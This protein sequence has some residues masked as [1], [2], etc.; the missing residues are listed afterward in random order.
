MKIVM[1]YLLSYSMQS[2]SVYGALRGLELCTFDYG[3]KSVKLHKAPWYIQDKPRFTYCGLMLDTSR[4]YLPVEIIKQVIESMSYAKL[5][6]RV[7][8]SIQ[9]YMT[10]HFH[11]KCHP[12]QSCGKAHIQSGSGTLWM[13]LVNLLGINVMAEVDVP[14]HAESW[15]ED[16]NMTG[17]D[18]Y[19]YFVLKA[20]KIAMSLN[21][22][23]VN[24]EETFNTFAE[25]LNPSTIYPLDQVYY[26]DRLED[27]TDALEQ[28]LVLG[29][30]VRMWG[31]TV[32]ASNL[33]QT[34]WPRA[35]VAADEYFRCLLTR[36]G[37][38][39]APVTNF[40]ARRSPTGPD[41]QIAGG[42]GLI[43]DHHGELL[44]ALHSSFQASSSFDAEI[45]AFA[46]GLILASHKS[47]KIDAAVVTLLSS[48]HRGSWVFQGP[49][50]SINESQH[51]EHIR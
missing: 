25:R 21:W 32:D 40:Y 15:L 39:A 37:V 45:Q 43:R 49:S 24:W 8:N 27:I 26:A 1:N 41:I 17:K 51:A 18:A 11:L 19:Q 46:V 2:N 7:D 30:E 44:L 10:N 31:E 47:I 4:H 38:P 5:V 34:I 13:L 23:P 12:F 28:K 6:R 33:Q 29:G 22:T 16:H 48:G 9:R 35:A 20:Q 42:G 3:T 14:G 50:S 36:R